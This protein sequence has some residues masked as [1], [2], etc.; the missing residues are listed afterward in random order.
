MSTSIQLHTTIDFY[1]DLLYAGRLFEPHE[2]D[3]MFATLAAMGMKRVNWIVHTWWTLDR[4]PI[5]GHPNLLSFL[6]EKAHAHGLEIDAHI[7]PYEGGFSVPGRSYLPHTFPKPKGVAIIDDLRGL[8]PIC[9]PFAAANPHLRYQRPP[10]DCTADREITRIDL[11]KLGTDPTRI[12][13]EHLSLYVGEQNGKL[14]PFPCEFELVETIEWREGFTHGQRCRVLS[15]RGF[16][17]PSKYRYVFVRCSVTEGEPDF[18]NIPLRL[19]EIYDEQGDSLPCIPAE[20]RIDPAKVQCPWPETHVL[21][22]ALEDEVK[23]FFA[24]RK[25]VEAAC[26]DLYVYDRRSGEPYHEGSHYLD[27]R[28]FAGVACGKNPAMQGVLNL[29]HPEVQDYWLEIVNEAITAGV[30]G[31]NIRFAGHSSKS[32]ERDEYGLGEMQ[33]MKEARLASGRIDR[34]KAAQMNGDALTDWL[35]RV[36]ELTRTRNVRFATHIHSSFMYPDERY[37]RT[38]HNTPPAPNTDFQWKRWIEEIR[39]DEVTLKIQNLSQARHQRFIDSV[40]GTASDAGVKVT[41]VGG[42]IPAIQ[43]NPGGR[44]MPET[45]RHLALAQND[46]RITAFDFYEVAFYMKLNKKG[47]LEVDVPFV[48]LIRELNPDA[49]LD[50]IATSNP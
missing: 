46:P 19:M 13:A 21:P 44:P 11:V 29:I 39:M 27:Q 36:R 33:I 42:A 6:V 4:E 20:E 15:L 14:E 49:E 40:A 48:D 24:D 37:W 26:R 16:R 22:Y 43:L 41:Y 32:H 17:I 25:K 23:A 30:D 10:E 12:R 35:K 28:G 8:T 47:V 18:G 38:S 7:K 2:Y 1:D 9:D 34:H 3:A 5:A 31:I 50:H 45:C